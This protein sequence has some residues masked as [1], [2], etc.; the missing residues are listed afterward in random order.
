MWQYYRGVYI[1]KNILFEK[2]LSGNYEVLPSYT[3]AQQNT[4]LLYWNIKFQ[5]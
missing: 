2:K 1:L 4:E 5:L 3:K